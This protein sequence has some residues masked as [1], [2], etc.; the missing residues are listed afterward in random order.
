MGADRCVWHRPSVAPLPAATAKRGDGGPD[1]DIRSGP[2]RQKS[3]SFSIAKS[4]QFAIAID[5]QS[6]NTTF[7]NNS[8]TKA[9]LRS[10]AAISY[11]NAAHHAGLL[12][13]RLATV[14]SELKLL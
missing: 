14:L 6:S 3:V 1:A 7:D 10:W 4:V 8:T 5:S 12:L 9:W 11:D 13:E 2:D